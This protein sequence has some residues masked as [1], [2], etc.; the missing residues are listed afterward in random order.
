VKGWLA[1]IEFE[2]NDNN[3][4]RAQ[5]IYERAILNCPDSL[6]LWKSFLSFAYGKVKNWRLFESVARRAIKVETCKCEVE[7]WKLLILSLELA[8]DNQDV[9]SSSSTT[10]SAMS[11]Y[12][13]ELQYVTLRS[14]SDYI[15]VLLYRCNYLRRKLINAINSNIPLKPSDLLQAITSLRESYDEIDAFLTQYYPEWVEGWIMYLLH[16]V[17]I[18]DDIIED[19][20]SSLADRMLERTVIQSMSEQLWANV[21]NKFYKSYLFWST[22]INWAKTKKDIE[23]CR[24]L[25]KR[26]LAAVENSS[27]NISNMPATCFEETVHYVLYSDWMLCEEKNGNSPTDILIVTDLQAKA[28]SKFA[29]KQATN[30][31]AKAANQTEIKSD[32]SSRKRD[33]AAA[34]NQKTSAAPPAKKGSTKRNH[35]ENSIAVSSTEVSNSNASGLTDG[36]APKKNRTESESASVISD[37]LSGGGSTL[38]TIPEDME[39]DETTTTE[40]GSVFLKNLSFKCTE[41]EIRN[42]FSNCGVITTVQ[43][44][45]TQAGKHR[46]MAIIEFQDKKSVKSAMKL[47]NTELNDRNI[48]VERMHPN[49]T[50]DD[51]YNEGVESF[52]PTTIFVNKLDRS[53]VTEEQ[54]KSFFEEKIGNGSVLSCHI[55]VDKQSGHPKVSFVL[56][57]ILFVTFKV[58]C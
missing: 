7:I 23:M 2:I 32:S 37:H 33:T 30:V 19:I 18:E 35:D 9:L 8:S 46:G 39:V 47:H 4:S 25:F 38:A 41:D 27:H 52:H 58:Q 56:F 53:S 44:Q 55:A 50:K 20:G 15:T 51:K 40:S 31:T 22:Y 42:L 10:A 34:S 21:S 26:A 54:L 16:R 57:F 49:Y 29:S 17:D 28:S 48:V 45:R 43:I 11:A 14:G 3:I 13:T 6:I 24:K 5:R 1:Y 12:M 36:P